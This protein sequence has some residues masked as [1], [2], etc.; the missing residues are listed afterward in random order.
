MKERVFFEEFGSL[1]YFHGSSKNWEMKGFHFH[2]QYEIILF[3]S[4]GAT[5]ETANRIYHAGPGDLFVINNKEYHRTRIEKGM[6][7]RRY[8]LMFD[9]EFLNGMSQAFSYDFK[10]YFENRNDD[11]IHRLHLTEIH[12]KRIER[13]FKKIETLINSET[14]AATALK[15]QLA[16]LELIVAINELYEFFTLKEK[17]GGIEEKE[18]ADK[19]QFKN[20][21]LYR[22]RIE[23]IKRYI[24]E[25]LDEKLELDDIAREF[26]LS[27]HYL[28]H[29]FKKETGFT[30]KQYVT[31]QKI[32]AAKVMLAQGQSVT[33]VASRL[34]YQTDSHFISIFK[35]I[36]GITPKKYALSKKSNN[37]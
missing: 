15:I 34:A 7:Y 10:K 24:S 30:I 22:E 25:N 8:V 1:Y 13:M 5:L 6:V 3:L 16:I 9:P 4:E 32:S 27:R 23:Q 36:T 17:T 35:K 21:V 33:E 31:N 12:K 20:P 26:Y 2:K 29:Y 19:D 14:T 28:S 18:T 37:E 11:F